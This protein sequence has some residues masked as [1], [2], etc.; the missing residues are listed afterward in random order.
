M[1]EEV[2]WLTKD[3]NAKYNDSVAAV[4][5]LKVDKARRIWETTVPKSRTE[6]AEVSK[7]NF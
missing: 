4:D 5:R 7:L 6:G 2:A 1:V 3:E